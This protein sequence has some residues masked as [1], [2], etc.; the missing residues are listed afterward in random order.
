MRGQKAYG[1]G[2]FQPPQ[3]RGMCCCWG[4]CLRSVTVK[5]V[6]FVVVDK[7]P[8]HCGVHLGTVD[9]GECKILAVA[10]CIL[11]MLR[12]VVTGQV[13]CVFGNEWIALNEVSQCCVAWC[14]LQHADE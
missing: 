11:C 2:D 3:N 6:I 9:P 10:Y 14:V 8:H 7:V 5:V 4:L 13:W 1:D 12:V